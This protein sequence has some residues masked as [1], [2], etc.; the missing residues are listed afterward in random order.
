MSNETPAASRPI[1]IL[2][3]E[4]NEADLVLTK[5]ALQRS[6]KVANRIGVA[7]DGAEAIDYVFRRGEFA[8]APMPD[9][10]ILD[11]NLPKFSGF[12]V[13][14]AIRKDPATSH[15]PV[16]IMTGSDAETDIAK[17]YALHASCYL[18]K[19]VKLENFLK[20]VA[21]L[22]DFWLTTVQLPKAASGPR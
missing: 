1:E 13:L 3:V 11:L 9:L 6:A 4:D 7:R 10:V 21:S 5:R 17:A 14:E 20:N 15:L 18:T 12:E 22:V 16:I 8:S 19:P 2:L